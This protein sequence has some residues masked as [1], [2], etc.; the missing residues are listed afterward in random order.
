M[1][2]PAQCVSRIQ[3]VGLWKCR[4]G[5]RELVSHP[6][7]RT[8][9][10]TVNNVPPTHR[11][12]SSSGGGHRHSSRARRKYRQ[13][14]VDHETDRYVVLMRHC[15]AQASEGTARVALSGLLCWL[16]TESLARGSTGRAISVRDQVLSG[17]LEL[18]ILTAVVK[19]ERDELGE[20]RVTGSEH[21]V[22]VVQ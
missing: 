20:R 17:K 15:S 4:P 8:S 1:L 13:S 21:Q 3:E 22:R 5:L 18:Q 11:V 2:R 16:S 10:H 12:G 9:V 14:A 19:A 6:E 7:L